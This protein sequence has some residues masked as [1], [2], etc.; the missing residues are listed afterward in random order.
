[1]R[2][3]LPFFALLLVACHRDDADSTLG[4]EDADCMPD[5]AECCC[6]TAGTGIDCMPAISECTQWKLDNCDVYCATF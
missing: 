6:P 3:A 4:A 1:M 2:Y 5:R